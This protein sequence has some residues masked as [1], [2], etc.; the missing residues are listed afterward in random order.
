MVDLKEVLVLPD[1]HL[2]VPNIRQHKDAKVLLVVLMVLLIMVLMVEVVVKVDVSGVDGI[3]VD[4][5]PVLTLLNIEIAQE[6]MLCLEHRVVQVGQVELVG[7]IIT[8]VDLLP[9]HLEIPE[10]VVAAPRM[11]D[12]VLR[13]IQEQMVANG[14]KQV[15]VISQMVEHPEDPYPEQIIQLQDQSIQT[16]SKVP[17]K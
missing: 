12:R 5:N 9:E 13:A 4:V 1:M 15:Q 7:G 10:L 2:S 14:D 3:R 17:T 8:L 16:P 11:V 6:F